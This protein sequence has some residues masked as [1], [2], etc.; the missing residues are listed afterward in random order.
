M[1]DPETLG[2]NCYR[3]MTPGQREEAIRPLEKQSQ[4]KSI[5][6]FDRT[7]ATGWLDELKKHQVQ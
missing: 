5:S 3:S 4:C 2:R 1:E 7:F 6:D